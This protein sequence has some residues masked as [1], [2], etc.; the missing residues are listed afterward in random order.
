MAA[1][2]AQNFYTNAA[3]RDCRKSFEAKRI[4]IDGGMCMDC[5]KKLGEIA[6]HWPTP[7]N[8]SNIGD[9]AISLNHDNLRL[10]CKECHD[11]YPGHGVNKSLTPRLEFDAE[12]NP[13]PPSPHQN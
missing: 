13:I 1:E 2:W 9:P 7:L 5:G 8:P 10:V 12:G 3:W 4:A 6:H 11:K